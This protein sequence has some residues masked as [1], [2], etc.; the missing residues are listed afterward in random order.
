MSDVI[1]RP[2]AV[3]AAIGWVCT[4]IASILGLAG[5]DVPEWMSGVAFFVMF[6]LWL[7]VVLYMQSLIKGV[8]HQDMWKA[9]F[10]GC[11]DWLRY[12][13]WGAWGYSFLMFALI[14][15]GQETAGG[16]G[17]IGTFYASALGV[18]VTVATTG[19]KPALC[20]NGHEIGPF[21][22]FCSQC[23]SPKKTQST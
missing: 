12:A 17:F 10:R 20:A 5:F 13:I 7:I 16:I 15:A 14:A 18:F 6:P 19:N 22:E 23:G 8:R 3:I 11:P 4:L 9:A 2:L 1:A 21:D